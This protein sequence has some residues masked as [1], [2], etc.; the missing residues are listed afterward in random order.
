ME[1]G[2]L[3]QKQNS[4][5][6]LIKLNIICYE[7][8]KITEENKWEAYDILN[9]VKHSCWGQKRFGT[10]IWLKNDATFENWQ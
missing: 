1:R 10:E 8:N 5:W 9:N 7:P 2:L 3:V 4:I 6:Y